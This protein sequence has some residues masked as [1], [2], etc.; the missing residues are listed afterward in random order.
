MLQ[1]KLKWKR[2]HDAIH[3]FDLKIAQNEGL[4]FWET[5]SNVIILHSTDSTPPDC[6]MK[7]LDKDND[8]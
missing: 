7:F 2:H 4:I 5:L 3:W 6:L 8:T 1:Y